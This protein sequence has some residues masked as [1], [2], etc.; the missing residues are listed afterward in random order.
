VLIDKI[1]AVIDSNDGDGSTTRGAF[2][3]VYKEG[4][5]SWQKGLFELVSGPTNAKKRASLQ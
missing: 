3:R 5:V 1:R 2:G 4:Y